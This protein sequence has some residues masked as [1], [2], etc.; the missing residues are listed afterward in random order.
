MATM[1]TTDIQSA[2]SR[3][4]LALDAPDLASAADLLDRLEGQVGV[5]K[6]GL[7]LF[8]AAGPAAVE[9][10]KKRGYNVFLDL[11]LHDIPNTVAGAVRSA[12]SLGVSMLTVHIGGARAM[13]EAA[14]DAANPD[15]MLLGVTLLTSIGA[16][17][18]P[19]AAIAGTPASAVETRAKLASACGL[20]GIVCSPKEIRNVRSI[21]KP[22]MAV[23]TPGIRP[24]GADMG[25]QKRAA[26]PEAAIE[27]GASYLVVGRPITAAADPAK[28]AADI[29]ASIAKA[30]SNQ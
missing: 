24:G 30:L 16:E 6:V 13:L 27:D 14:R 19:D 20:G 21:I 12:N 2:K 7:E 22:S 9:V 29:A 10:V 1:T 23:V 15:L 3:L 18:M 26:T 25:D 17:D 28:A 8:T 5:V 11:K 4:I